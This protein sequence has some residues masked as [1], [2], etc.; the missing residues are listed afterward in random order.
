M[1]QTIGEKIA[2][3]RKSKNITQT[4]LAEY[5]FLVPQTISKWEA[6]NGSPDISLLPKIAD[7]FDISLDDLF[8]RASLDYAK[9]LVLKYSVLRDDHCFREAFSC[10]QSQLHTVDSALQLGI[11]APEE[12]EQEK[13]EL[14]AYKMHLLLQQSRES[15]QRAL[16]IAED[17][18]GRT[19]DMR[20]RLQKIQLRIEL[21]EGRFVL[22]ECA[23]QFRADPCIDTLRLYFEALFLLGRDKT[24]LEIRSAD[25]SVQELMSP[26]SPENA[27]LWLQCARSAAEMGDAA[28]T[29][30][31][32]KPI[33]QCR[34]KETEYFFYWYLAELYSKKEMRKECEALKPRLIALL[35]EID[36]NPYSAARHRQSIEAL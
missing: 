23:A 36:P 7:F 5:L 1:D 13:T 20:F 18:A 35:P 28:V 21:G 6:G 4:Q 24:L 33:C 11:K 19:K 9:D 3:L 2:S 31:F 15:A 10:L 14:E 30:S 34:S 12:L 22:S 29:Q 16:K 8:G 27:P 26:P 32:A 17:A 25:T